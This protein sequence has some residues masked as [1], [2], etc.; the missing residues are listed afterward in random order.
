MP[1]TLN[2][3]SRSQAGGIT[4]LVALMLLVFLSLICAG[5]TRNSFRE[6]L[7]SGTARQ[8]SMARSSADSGI[9]WAMFWIYP[10]NVPDATNAS[11]QLFAG[12]TGLVNTL[13]ANQTLAGHYVQ[14]S[15]FSPAAP[16]LYTGPGNQT[17]PADLAVTT[18]AANVTEGFTLSLMSMG[19]LP[20][21]NSSQGTSSGTYRAVAGSN[22]DPVLPDLW[23]VRSDGQVTINGVTFQQSREAWIS[24]PKR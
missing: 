21:K 16:V 1:D 19:S 9:E 7:T 2:A 18:P 4:I 24:T 11:A 22:V 6:I 20:I 15:N 14:L 5:M 17:M 23:A 3:R 10:N 13:L 12:P 8:A